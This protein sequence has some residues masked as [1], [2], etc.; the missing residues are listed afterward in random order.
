[1]ATNKLHLVHWIQN[2]DIASISDAYARYYRESVIHEP[3]TPEKV[4]DLLRYSCTKQPD[5]FFAAYDEEGKPEGFVLSFVRPFSDGNHLVDTEVFVDP[6][7]SLARRSFA[8]KELTVKLLETAVRDVHVMAIDGF[9]YEDENGFPLNMYQKMHMVEDRDLKMFTAN[10]SEFLTRIEK[11]LT[12]KNLNLLKGTKSQDGQ[13]F[14]ISNAQ[15]REDLRI[16]GEAYADY[17]KDSKHQVVSWDP[18]S[19]ATFL[20][21]LWMKQSDLFFIMKEEDKPLGFIASLI[22]PWYDG[23]NVT[24]IE[25]FVVPNLSSEKRKFVA[26]ILMYRLLKTAQDIYSAVTVTG[27]TY[28]DEKD[29]PINMFLNM[30]IEVDDELIFVT[31]TPIEMLKRIKRIGK[32]TTVLQAIKDQA[33]LQAIRDQVMRKILNRK[34]TSVQLNPPKDIFLARKGKNPNSGIVA[35][36]TEE[37]NLP[38]SKEIN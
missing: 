7:L 23:Y 36:H 30:G 9:A 14:S 26:E 32:V 16:L 29:L 19:A 5:L 27:S 15:S 35:S 33:V 3:W 24:N 1:M 18:E 2:E 8:A 6:R 25:L 37:D 38:T 17:Y 10:I 21:D 20:R 13:A 22:K 34:T 11:E 31:G 4:A 28:P 12:P